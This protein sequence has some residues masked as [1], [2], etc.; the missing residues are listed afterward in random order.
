[1]DKQSLTVFIATLVIIGLVIAGFMFD[2]RV[3]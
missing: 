1:M 3:W 2:W